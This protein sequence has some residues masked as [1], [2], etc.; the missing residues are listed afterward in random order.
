MKYVDTSVLVPYYMPEVRSDEANALVAGGRD[1]AV[2]DISLAEFYVVIARKVRE[3]VLT[4]EAA[5]K[6]RG[7]F[8]NHLASG[9]YLRLPFRSSHVE[10]VRDLA[11]SS[12]IHLRT[13]DALHAVVAA[14]HGAEVITF[15]DRIAKA[16]RVLGL[17]VSP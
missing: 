17:A 1:S 8:E 6:A 9:L 5:D 4:R 7:L 14:Q 12:P 11:W 15:D 16:A 2:S 3:G 13:L 10:E